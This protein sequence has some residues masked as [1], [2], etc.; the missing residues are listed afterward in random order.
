M[1]NFL[2]FLRKAGLPETL[3]ETISAQMTERFKK[4]FPD[5]FDMKYISGGETFAFDDFS[6]EVIHSPGHTPGSVCFFE[7]KEGRLF[8]GDHLLEKITSNPMVEIENQ[9]VMSDYKSLSSYLS[10]LE[11]IKDMDVALVLPG[12]G[13]SFSNHR[14]RINAMRGHH[15]VRREEVLN[16]LKAQDE[17]ASTRHGVTPYWVC[18]QLFPEIEG[19]DVFLGLSETF[20]HL[21]M[22][23]EER[24]V[25]SHQEQGQQFYRLNPAV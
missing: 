25:K 13:S 7:P 9:D 24:S 2:G 23:E 11:L 6:L 1:E 18:R 20:A 14:K 22:L 10:S 15:R 17:K 4:F 5:R 19:W 16:T 12:H 21:E 3:M 8:S